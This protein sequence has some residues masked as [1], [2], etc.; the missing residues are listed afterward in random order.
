MAP[1]EGRNVRTNTMFSAVLTVL[2]CCILRFYLQTPKFTVCL[3]LK[4]LFIYFVALN[5]VGFE[6][7]LFYLKMLT[8][9]KFLITLAWLDLL[10]L[11]AWF[12]DLRNFSTFSL[13]CFYLLSVR[14]VSYMVNG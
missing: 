6:L 1:V 14:K 13:A 2:F 12:T 8:D 10:P 5:A 4:C 11:K 9:I 7:K 3:V